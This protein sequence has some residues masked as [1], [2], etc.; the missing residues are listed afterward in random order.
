MEAQRPN[1]SPDPYTE[2]PNSTVEDWHGQDLARGQELAD[3]VMAESGG[4]QAEAE[5]RFDDEIDSVKRRED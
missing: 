5:R 4:D 2:P 3:E 1:H